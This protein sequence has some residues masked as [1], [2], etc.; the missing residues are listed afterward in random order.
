V[1]DIVLHHVAVI[2]RDLLRSAAFY[3]NVLKL[4]RIPRPPFSIEG[5]WLNAG[6]AL[7]VHVTVYASGNFRTGSVDNDDV[8]FA[9]RT[10]DFEGVLNRLLEA[11]Y[12]PDA[13]GDD[14][15]RMILKRVGAA[16]F[17]QLY[18]MD[19]DRNIVEINGAP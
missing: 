13:S 16:G 3:E 19:P 4:E 10:S 9:F 8:H 15:V 18:V 2:T 12:N 11:G 14:P 17:P 1:A 7:Q 5:V 6:P